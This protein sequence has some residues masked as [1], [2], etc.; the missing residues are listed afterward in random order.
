MRAMTDDGHNDT[1]AAKARSAEYPAMVKF[2]WNRLAADRLL[3]AAVQGI[4]SNR[5]NYSKK[6]KGIFS[7]K[8]YLSKKAFP[9][10]VHKNN[11]QVFFLL[12]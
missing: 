6:T 7:D 8:K 12:I 9:F 10:V 5:T 1:S 4:R 3:N 2:Q 11:Q